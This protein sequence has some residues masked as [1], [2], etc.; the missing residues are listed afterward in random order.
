MLH[1]PYI[2]QSVRA[3]VEDRAQKNEKGQFLDANTGQ[4]I[5]GKYD[6]GHKTGHEF[7]SEKAK[8]ES[9]GLTQK[10][11]NDRMNNPDLYQIEDPSSNRS[12]Q[13]E[14]KEDP[15]NTKDNTQ[16]VSLDNTTST[17]QDNTQDTIQDNTQ[18]TTQDSIQESSTGEDGGQTSEAP[19]GESSGQ[20]S[21]GESGGEDGGEDG[22][23]SM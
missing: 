1:R 15:A 7:R 8:A 21:A 12:H 2:R 22:G 23:Q 14:A 17:V 5:E 3:E 19:S 6:L 20:S 16:D 18:D 10:E 11:F 13:F 9:E 4:P